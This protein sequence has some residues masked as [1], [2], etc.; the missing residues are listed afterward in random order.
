MGG[1]ETESERELRVLGER[2]LEGV[3]SSSSVY[4]RAG[5]PRVEWGVGGGRLPV[6]GKEERMEERSEQADLDPF[7][8]LCQLSLNRRHFDPEL[9]LFYFSFAK[10]P[11]TRLR[12]R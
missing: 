9:C 4:T 3:S 11:E 1:G 8:R 5:D 12:E 7:N 10:I 2:L 6:K